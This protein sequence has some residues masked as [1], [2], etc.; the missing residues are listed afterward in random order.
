LRQPK[1]TARWFSQWTNPKVAALFNRP[2]GPISFARI[3]KYPVPFI[4]RQVF[5]K[6]VLQKKTL[7]IS[8]AI[9]NLQFPL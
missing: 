6:V 9:V 5:T 4:R 1:K 7:L 2:D 8:R 3:Q